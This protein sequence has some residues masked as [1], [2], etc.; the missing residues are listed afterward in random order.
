MANELNETMIMADR[1]SVDR[2]MLADGSGG[3]EMAALIKRLGIAARG[4]WQDCDDDGATLPLGDGR[5]LVFTTDSYTVTPLFF[6]GGNIGRLA[7]SGTVNDLAVMGA[8]PVGISLAIVLEEGFPLAD[9]DRI[10]E[11]VRS[12][13]AEASVP[14]VTGDTK[15]MEK[16]KIDG[17]VITTSGVGIVSDGERLVHLPKPGDVVI[18]SGGL[19]EHAVALLSKR[20]EYETA[21]VSDCKPLNA[22]MREIRPLIKIAKDP[23]RG[24]IASSLNE[25][26]Q[27]YKIGMILKESDVPVRKDV[28]AVVDMLGINLYELACEGRI[29]CVSSPEN[30]KAVVEKLKKHNNDAAI[31]GQVTSGSE[32]VIQTHLGRRVLP[33]PTGRIVPRIC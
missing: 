30:A 11:S 19:G 16:G 18:L 29:I 4:E 2:V 9:L 5:R 28:R 7:I 27:K 33:M 15:V 23:T 22:E 31:I 24:G 17:M 6:P 10:M 1:I 32:V 3:K 26:C 8:D 25:M 12:A 14:V 20:F 21:V 13:A